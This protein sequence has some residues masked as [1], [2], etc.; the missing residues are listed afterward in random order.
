MPIYTQ[1]R[2]AFS[3]GE[4]FRRNVCF[5]NFLDDF[6]SVKPIVYQAHKESNE[7]LTQ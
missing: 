4:N 3:L 2:A 1:Y 7:Q 6:F 5:L